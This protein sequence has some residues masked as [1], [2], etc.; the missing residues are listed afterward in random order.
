ME[1]KKIPTIDMRDG[2]STHTPTFYKVKKYTLIVFVLLFIISSAS[3]IYFALQLNSQK[4][5]SVQNQEK[6]L[7]E[8]IKKVSELIV[9]PTNETPTLATVSDPSKLKDQAFFANAQEGDK[10]L[11]YAKA[12]KAILYNP[13]M[14]KI[15]DVSPL[16]P[17]AS[18]TKTPIQK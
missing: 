7:E 4:E 14:N 18:N 3:A 15:V 10:V 6:E 5:V 2:E 17:T 11:I 12:G 16:A 13:K 8:I 9:L 1:R